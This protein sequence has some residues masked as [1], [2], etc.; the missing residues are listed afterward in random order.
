MAICS[1]TRNYR[2]IMVTLSKI[3]T[4]D[5]SDAD[6]DSGGPF[7]QLSCVHRIQTRSYIAARLRRMMRDGYV[8]YSR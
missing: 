7:S 3:L 6:N 5:F 4:T 1:N 8:V 2:E